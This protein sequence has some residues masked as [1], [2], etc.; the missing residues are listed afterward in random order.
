MWGPGRHWV[1]G[2]GGGVGVAWVNPGVH[3]WVEEYVW[4]GVEW[5]SV[6]GGLYGWRGVCGCMVHEWRGVCRWR[7]VAWVKGCHC[8][9][10]CVCMGGGFAWVEGCV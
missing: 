1:H 2:R 9:E 4:V 10:G 7:W 6:A 5:G 8:V 3:A